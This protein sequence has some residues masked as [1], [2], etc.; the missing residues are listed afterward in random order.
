MRLVRLP[1]LITTASERLHWLAP[2]FGGRAAP[3][4][5]R[6]VAAAAHCPTAMAALARL[7]GAAAAQALAP[8]AAAAAHSS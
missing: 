7:P 2:P 5:F 1:N 3:G 6:P 8:A 4:R